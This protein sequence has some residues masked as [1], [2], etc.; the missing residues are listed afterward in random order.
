M[1]Q[2]ENKITI[3]TKN[4]ADKFGGKALVLDLN[5]KIDHIYPTTTARHAIEGT[6]LSKSDH[7]FLGNI[8]IRLSGHVSNAVETPSK[9][10]EGE[11]DPY[12][13]FRKVDAFQQ[14]LDELVV[15]FEQDR[16]T[17][18][19]LEE[20]TVITEAQADALNRLTGIDEDDEF[21]Y[22]SGDALL[23]EDIEQITKDSESK[24]TGLKTR[25]EK[26]KQ[27]T[28]EK[29]KKER[30]KN[31]RP[32]YSSNQEYKQLDA[33]ELLEAVYYKKLLVDVLTTTKLYENM[34]MKRLSLPRSPETGSALTINITFEQQSFN[35]ST[36][37]TVS[38]RP[39]DVP[40]P[41]DN[42]KSQGVDGQKRLDKLSPEQKKRVDRMIRLSIG[43]APIK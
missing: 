17:I 25:S 7:S 26:R 15:I 31:L 23:L 38:T 21:A 10:K 13:K 11:Y 36:V 34:V 3:F 4:S 30:K 19:D 12:G 8:I 39:A 27:V 33:F 41:K 20:A 42:G 32:L 22:T 40:E 29:A 43:G 37:S 5:E 1:P 9:S 16:K 28:E 6:G 2:Q 24:I 35:S 14:T 18:D